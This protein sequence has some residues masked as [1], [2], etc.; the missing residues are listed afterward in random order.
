MIETFLAGLIHGNSYALVAVGVSL[1]FGVANVVNFAHGSVFGFGAMLGWWFLAVLD[2]PFVLSV[3]AVLVA[4]A[5]LG[6]VINAVAVKPLSRAPAIAALLATFAVSMILDNL[7][8]IIFGPQYRSFPEALPNNNLQIGILTFGTSDV[9]MLGVT[10]VVMTTLAL[11]LRYGRYGRAIRATAQD[12]DAA[13]QMGVPVGRVQALAFAIA[14]SLGGLAG[15]FVALYTTSVSPTSHILTG[16]IGF[17]AATI[18]GLGSISGAVLAG[19]L[20]GVVEAFGVYWLGEG[21]RDLLTFGALLVILVVRPHGLFGSRSA[22]ATEPMTGTFFGG[23][24]PLRL[25]RKTWLGLALIGV[26]L[27]PALATAPFLAVAYQVVLMAIVAVP[28]TLLSGSAGQVSLGQVAPLA[29]G[30]YAS[31]LLALDLGVPPLIAIPAAGLISALLVTLLTLPIWKLGGHYISIATLGVGYVVVALIR[32]AEPLTRGAYGL[33]GIPPLSIG[34]HV[35]AL[36]LEFYLVDLA[37]LVLALWVTMRI[38]KSHLGL[39]LNAVGSDQVAA[40][41]LGVRTRDY[42]ALSFAIAAFFAGISGALMAHQNGY[43]DPTLFLIATSVLALTII[44][45]GGINSPI[46]AVFGA[47]VLVGLPE[48]LRITPDVRILGYGLLLLVIIRFRPQGLFTRS[49]AAR[50]RRG[51]QTDDGSTPSGP[52][53]GGSTGADDPVLV[54]DRARH[55]EGA[56]A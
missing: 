7:S 48:L 31:A 12:P 24:R 23:G 56:T 52:P 2:W 39:T 15:I 29:V 3:A 41:S 11:F 5:I 25:G 51:G 22:I 36:P 10:L 43:I 30:A 9:V 20:L 35:L 54:R 34:G 26:V 6:L 13:R 40:R 27:I 38:R 17:V 14:S 42:K 19:F 47:I 18:G 46:G 44:V 49:E 33:P 28:M 16:M 1:V 4:T 55:L 45:L 8:Q 21:I 32:A 37:F 50:A 53:G